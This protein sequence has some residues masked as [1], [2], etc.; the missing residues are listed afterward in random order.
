MPNLEK[1]T[2]EYIANTDTETLNAE[3]KELIH[4][5]AE[6]QALARTLR[7]ELVRRGEEAKAAEDLAAMSPARR[8]AI[9]R[10]IANSKTT[11]TGTVS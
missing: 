11:G 10:A 4:F 3:R 5:Y 2:P 1:F 7:E 8:V 9:E 6:A